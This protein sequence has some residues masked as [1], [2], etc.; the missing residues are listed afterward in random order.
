M[1]PADKSLEV[2]VV[3]LGQAGGNLAAEMYRR[4]YRC[5]ALNTATTDLAALGRGRLTIPEESRLY[6]GIEGYDGAGADLNY[7]R[8]CIEAN[9]DTIREHVGQLAEVADL[10]LLTAGFG[11]GTG[12]ALSTLV[13]LLEPLELPLLAL[14][15]LPNDYESGI[16]KVNAVKAINQLVQGGGI[17]FVFVDNNRLAATFGKV[18]MDEYYVEINKRIC[19]P[20]DYFNTLNARKDATPIRAF[21]GED[22]RSVLMS[23]GILCFAETEVAELTVDTLMQGVRDA[24]QLGD[25]MPE[26]IALESSSYAAVIIEAPESVLHDTPFSAFEQFS[27]Q[28]KDETG[29]AAIYMGVYQVDEAQTAIIRVLCSTQA[30]PEGVHEMVSAAK[31]EGGKLREKLEQ[32]VAAL[33]LGEIENYELFGTSSGG[34]RAPGSSRRGRVGRR[35]FPAPAAKSKPQ[36]AAS[37]SAPV[38]SAAP[39]ASA[40]SS[41]SSAFSSSAPA[42]VTPSSS[43]PSRRESK[44]PAATA[45]VAPAVQSTKSVAP[46]ATP[47]IAPPA[48]GSP[49]A[50]DTYDDLIREYKDTQDASVRSRVTERLEADRQSAST[51]T[52]YYAVRAMTKLDPRLFSSALEAAADDEDSTVRAVAKRALRHAATV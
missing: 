27:E 46:V 5:L 19:E 25:M 38:A 11:G 7:G 24:V 42:A 23:N 15:T 13:D 49:A 18:G 31:R 9:A 37:S 48:G 26:G 33:D 35:R 17:G 14:A 16:A 41:A 47:S 32:Q 1:K 29:G 44:A 4:G 20:L 21:D 22:L 40:A 3:G 50:S 51:L 45:S 28:L 6:I 34:T 39:S 10:V 2:V 30:M 52:R 36:L 12:S 43:A 8:E